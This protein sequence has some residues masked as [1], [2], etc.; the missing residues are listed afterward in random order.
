MMTISRTGDPILLPQG[1]FLV[2]KIDESNV[3]KVK[4]LHEPRRAILLESHSRMTHM[5]KV[6]VLNG[7]WWVDES[8][9]QDLIGGIGNA[10]QAF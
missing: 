9:I 7:I 6:Y 8:E 2:K 5:R 4:I 3:G 1:A 10:C